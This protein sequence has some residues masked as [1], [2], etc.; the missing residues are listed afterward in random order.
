[1]RLKKIITVIFMLF[2]LFAFTGPAVMA[3]AASI[4]VF[5]DGTEV[6]FP[7]QKPFINSD[8]R[9]L[10]PVRFVSEALGAEVEWISETRTVKINYKEKTI[11]LGIGL[12]QALV[13]TSIIIL[14]TNAA[15]VNDRTMVPLRF[16]SEC[17][18]AEVVWKADE[19]AVYITTAESDQAL[20]DSDL[21]II[22]PQ[23]GNPNKID[24]QVL[25]LYKNTTP[26]APQIQDLKELLEKRFGDKA[27]EIVEYVAVKK[28][29]QSRIHPKDWV[30]DGKNIS[31]YDN[32][33]SVSVTV[34]G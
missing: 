6:Q 17:L 7:D 10:V 29:A 14:D 24:L 30:I 3:A 22:L 16:V 27:Q 8:N 31:V 5:V 9:T 2:L 23:P 28:E 20:V 1:M 34:W 26:V 18:G 32:V 21:R 13:G 11:L 33:G 15:I 12:K 19:Q 25:I 4:R